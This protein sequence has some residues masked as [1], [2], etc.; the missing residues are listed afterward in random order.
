MER[1]Q[2]L[3]QFTLDI[4]PEIQEGPSY[5]ANESRKRWKS[6]NRAFSTVP[7]TPNQGLGSFRV[8]LNIPNTIPTTAGST[9]SN[10]L[11][12]FSALKERLAS[13]ASNR[14]IRIR[15]DTAN[16]KKIIDFAPK[17]HFIEFSSLG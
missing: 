2:T 15:N 4:I 14:V 3:G 1:S 13:E 17:L 11:I 5:P 6:A 10:R 7:R 16:R 8:T 12:I 9:K